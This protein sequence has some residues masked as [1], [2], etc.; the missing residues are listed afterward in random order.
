M[1]EAGPSTAV[2]AKNAAKPRKRFVGSKSATPSKPGYS[3]V[4]ANQIP[5]DILND[6]QLNAAIKQLPSNYSFEIHKTIHHVRK[7]QAKMVALQ[8]PEGLQMFA[9][10]IAD[11]IE[12]YVIGV[13][14]ILLLTGTQLYKCTHRD[15]GRCHIW[16]LLH[17]RLHSCCPRMRHARSLW[18]QL[19]RSV[20]NTPS[21]LLDMADVILVPIDQ[22]TIKT[23]YI[24]VEISID[25]SHLVQTIRLNF[26]NDRR[27]FRESLLDQ[28]E[29]RS[30][31]PA[32]Q[33]LNGG[34]HLRI[35]GPSSEDTTAD[36]TAVDSQNPDPSMSQELTR[37]ALVSTIQFVSALS[38]LKDEL[39]VESSSSDVPL[40]PAGLLEGP[41]T[42]SSDAVGKPRLWT[43]KYDVTI[44]RTK[45]LSPGEILGCTAPRLDD[46]DALL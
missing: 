27:R 7:N 5:Q 12:R 3:P 10:T 42:D 32:G 26:P 29:E 38:N 14:P 16:R 45:P 13:V 4:V 31:L 39:S 24:F 6:A 17:R 23:L 8:M 44:P 22:T 25:S 35:E 2:P 37:L 20:S 18:P 11:I 36:N 19:S 15:H 33:L 41:S 40:M 28:E 34:G 21:L 43:G 9:C 46:V 1:S 30:Q